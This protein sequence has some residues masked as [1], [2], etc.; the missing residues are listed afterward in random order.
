VAKVDKVLTKAKKEIPQKEDSPQWML[1]SREKS[2]AREAKPL[3]AVALPKKATIKNNCVKPIIPLMKV[4]AVLSLFLL[5]KDM[6]QSLRK[7]RA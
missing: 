6:A 4:R 2:L 5:F 7:N 3:M 1:K